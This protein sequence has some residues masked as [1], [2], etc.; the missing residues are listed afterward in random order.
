M[1]QGMNSC[2]DLKFELDIQFCANILSS[3]STLR[4]PEVPKNSIKVDIIYKK[5]KWRVLHI[6]LKK[7]L[8][9]FHKMESLIPPYFRKKES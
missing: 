8:R 6:V 3:G 9:D 2:L 1:V 5:T 4:T 7:N